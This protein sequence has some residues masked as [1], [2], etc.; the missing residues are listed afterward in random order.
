M[1]AT[2]T[3]CGSRSTLDNPVRWLRGRGFHPLRRSFW[4]TPASPKP[5]HRRRCP[6]KTRLCES[7]L[8]TFKSGL[9]ADSSHLTR[10][11]SAVFGI[12]THALHA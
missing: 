9:L 4:P 12:T 2:P 11:C 8:R 7:H 3:S 5:I 1:L 10:T 6:T